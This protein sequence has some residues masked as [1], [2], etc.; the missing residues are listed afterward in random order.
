MNLAAAL[1][2]VSGLIAVGWVITALV[3]YRKIVK[4]T[5]AISDYREA[6][7][8]SEGDRDRL[9]KELKELVESDAVE[10]EILRGQL[11]RLRET[12]REQR[13]ELRRRLRPG[14]ALRGLQEFAP[15]AESGGADPD[16]ED[17]ED[18]L[19]ESP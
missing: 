14:D 5:E 15:K 12:N 11:E 16:P 9:E 3:L 17:H 13:E 2:S 19:G 4:K 10:D 1:G 18:L 7:T 8:K 6:L